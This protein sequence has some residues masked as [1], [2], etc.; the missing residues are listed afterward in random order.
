MKNNKNTTKRLQSLD[1]L[2]GLTVAGMILVNDGYGDSF[3]T[4]Q[5]S[6]WNGMTPCDL[7]FPFF[8]Y[9]VGISTY[10]SLRKYQFQFSMPA[11]RKILKR[12]VLIFVIGLAINWLANALEGDP[13]WSH[14]RIMGVMQRIALCYGITAVLA[15]LMNHKYV[16]PVSIGLLVV[17]AI[18]LLV[19]NGYA[20]D[21]SNIAARI[22]NALLGYD[23]L[24]HKSPVDPE[25]L[26]GTLSAVAHTMIGFWCGRAMMK[27]KTT[28]EKVMRFLL[29]GG[30][31]VIAAY[32]LQYGLPLNK[33]IWSPS[34]VLMTCGLAS[35]LQG[36][37][38]Y[39]IDVQGHQRWTTPFLIFGVNPLFLYVLSEVLAIVFGQYGI[40]DAIYEAIHSV[41]TN[42]YW[43]SLCYA[44]TYVLM[45]GIPGYFLWK[46]R[47]YI[48]I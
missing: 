19:G 8:L 12:T 45:C 9:I 47:I 48:K 25:G 1:V 24:Y 32:L 6:V 39:S 3:V 36:M 14:L 5:H 42:N 23:H 33:R 30:V 16:L 22:D 28:N 15:L 46:K 2:R 27:S 43:A 4:L 10:L 34:Y 18:I 7:V 26:L 35:L 21:G 29:A 20:E 40:N 37:L 38:M 17:Y 44:L 13:G 41:V 31:M 11:V